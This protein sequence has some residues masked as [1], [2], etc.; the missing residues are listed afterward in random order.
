MT[1][2]HSK[3]KKHRRVWIIILV[4]ILAAL[5][6]PP[7][8]LSILYYNGQR[9]WQNADAVPSSPSSLVERVEDEGETVVYGGKTY[10]YN[11]DRVA[12][13]FLGVDKE[14]IHRDFGYGRN[15]QADS[16]FLFVLDTKTGKS[17][18][19]PLSREAMVDVDQYTVSGG[20]G[21]T[22]KEQLCLAYAYGATGDESCRNVLTSVNRLLYGMNIENYVAIDLA[23]VTKMTDAVGG[24]T[25]ITDKP[26][27][28]SGKTVAA[29]S[30]LTLNGSEAKQF[31]QSRD[32]SVEANMDRMARQ[33]LFLNAFYQRIGEKIKKNFS[34]LN[35]YYQTAKPYIVTNLSLSE[36]TYLGGCV[37]GG[38]HLSSPT[39]LSIEGKT[40]DGKAHSEFHPDSRSVYEAVLAAFYTEK[41]P[42]D[43]LVN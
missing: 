4:A 5:L 34:L 38:A 19:L 41:Q 35:S 16:L 6:I 32:Y 29:G 14:D 1:P 30:K 10:V 25:L 22:K 17:F 31:V 3:Q 21:G 39:Y 18:I 33:K 36:I 42:D 2:S 7:A 23:G 40:V 8:T 26:Y 20:F 37:V 13:L 28:Y 27:T 12:V 9:Q 24:V 15:G 43:Q 11:H